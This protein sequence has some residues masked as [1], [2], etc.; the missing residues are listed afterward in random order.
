M[1]GDIW[2]DRERAFEGQW[3]LVHDA[4]LI[5]ETKGAGASRGNHR[6]TGEEAGG[7]SAG[8]SSAGHRPGHHARD[9]PCIAAGT[10][11]PDCLG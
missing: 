8:T 10:P 6:G 11:G 9:R 7:G 4:E 1:S 2:K 5:E 3:A